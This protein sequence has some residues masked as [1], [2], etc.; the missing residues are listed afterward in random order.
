MKASVEPSK[1]SATT[2]VTERNNLNHG[3]SSKTKRMDST[4]KRPTGDESDDVSVITNLAHPV[5][6]SK[7]DKPAVLT[8]APIRRSGKTNL[9][10][11][12]TY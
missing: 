9:M 11:K 6:K 7:V 3:A 10:L 4:K 2:A 12:N 1:P 8:R 5:K